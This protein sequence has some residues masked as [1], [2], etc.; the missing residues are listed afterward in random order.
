MEVGS[1]A[2]L[3]VEQR[4]DACGTPC[5]HSGGQSHTSRFTL[6]YECLLNIGFPHNH[7]GAYPAGPSVAR[8]KAY[9]QISLFGRPRDCGLL[10][11][12]FW[13]L[14][15]LRH[16][17]AGHLLYLP[18]RRDMS[19]LARCHELCVLSFDTTWHQPSMCS[20]PRGFGRCTATRLAACVISGADSALLRPPVWLACGRTSS[21]VIFS[22]A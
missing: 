20:W 15:Y 18:V 22:D 10:Q 1:P 17:P 7:T 4:M 6:S 13:F 8:I 21:S 11:C 14:V 19:F 9:L 5:F 16:A 2:Q 12:V 3:P